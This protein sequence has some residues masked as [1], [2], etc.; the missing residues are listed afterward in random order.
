[1]SDNIIDFSQRK[2]EVEEEKAMQKLEELLDEAFAQSANKRNVH[3]LSFL[4]AGLLVDHFEALGYDVNEDPNTINDILIM[5]EIMKSMLG[6]I[7]GNEPTEY[8]KMIDSIC[9]D[10][11]NKEEVLSAFLETYYEIAT[12]YD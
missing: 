9:K 7:S 5:V 4:S 2:A 1:M 11:K 8:T 3:D 12:K 6:R 10:I